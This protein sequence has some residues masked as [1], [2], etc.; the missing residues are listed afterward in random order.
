MRRSAGEAELAELRER[1]RSMES[2]QAAQLEYLE[3][4]FYGQMLAWRREL[5]HLLERNF[6]S[7]RG[8]RV[9]D[10]EIGVH[11]SPLYESRVLSPNAAP[12]SPRSSRR[13][14]SHRQRNSSRGRSESP[15]SSEALRSSRLP[16]RYNP[17]VQQE[18]MD[19]IQS[20][21]LYS[22][23]HSGHGGSASVATR[24][25]PA[26]SSATTQPTSTRLFTP[27]VASSSAPKS[28]AAPFQVEL[29][30]VAVATSG[31][32]SPVPAASPQ[33]RAAWPTTSPRAAQM[34]NAA[35]ASAPAVTAGPTAR[36][37]NAAASYPSLPRAASPTPLSSPTASGIHIG[38]GAIAA[39]P[40][41]PLSRG[42]SQPV[43][44][45]PII[46]AGNASTGGLVWWSPTSVGPT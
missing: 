38:R 28:N 6:Q 21:M 13:T 42:L 30:P 43:P 23:V 40:A 25:Q 9:D 3:R 36:L 19:A 37:T 8:R 35:Q 4:Q 26:Q 27:G 39:M 1:V 11:E 44:A 15:M 2:T 5:T 12:R 24:Q 46:A 22:S 10:S 14:H 45:S 18:L 17:Q 20:T 31:L 16:L 7:S 41:V 32:P 29:W 33:A 34:E